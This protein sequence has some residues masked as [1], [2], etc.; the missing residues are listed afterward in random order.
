MWRPLSWIFEAIGRLRVKNRP[1]WSMPQVG[2]S[3]APDVASSNL[4]R[5]HAT[6]EALYDL[7]GPPQG[8]PFEPYHC[9]TL[10]AA[11]DHPDLKGKASPLGSAQFVPAEVL[12]L[13]KPGPPVQPLWLVQGTLVVLDLDGPASVAAAARLVA[14]GCQPVCTFDNWPHRRGVLK[15]EVTLGAMLRHAPVVAAARERLLPSSPPVW[16]CDRTRLTGARPSPGNFDNRYFL[17]DTVLPGTRVLRL[18]AIT[19][20]VLVIPVHA[21]TVQRDVRAWLAD[22]RKEGFETWVTAADDPDLDLRPLTLDREHFP[23]V[24]SRSDAGGFGALVPEPSSS[25]G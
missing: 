17:D 20:I 14:G 15:P 19:R 13:C 25:G 2:E 24:G 7:W 18:A 10:F 5:A 21:S 12:A 11:L 1:T 6:A 22:R 9:V 8:S 3:R 4:W 16:V 23:A